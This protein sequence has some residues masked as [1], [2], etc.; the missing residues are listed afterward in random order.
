MVADDQVAVAVLVLQALAVERGPP[1]GAAEQEAAG[2]RVA[3][4]PGQVADP[5]EAEHRVVDVER[6]HR[7]V[8]S[9]CSA[10][11]AAIHDDIAP[12]SLMPSCSIWPDLSSL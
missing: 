4:R 7:G 10:V 1:G 8:A 5:L 6:D 11:A 9:P 3:G 12:A 2:P